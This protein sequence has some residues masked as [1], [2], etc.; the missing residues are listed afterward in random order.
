[1][2]DELEDVNKGDFLIGTDILKDELINNSTK[3]LFLLIRL[4]L[5]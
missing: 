3:L 4:D 1:M 2:K 5:F